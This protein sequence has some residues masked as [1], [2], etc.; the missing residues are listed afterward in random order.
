[1]QTNDNEFV[2]ETVDEQI[3]RIE[4]FGT[5]SQ[6]EK[7]SPSPGQRLIDRL[8]EMYQEDARIGERVWQQLSRHVARNNGINELLHQQSHTIRRHGRFHSMRSSSRSLT[9]IVA[10]LFVA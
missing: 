7:R 6:N 2:P 10:A 1:M 3:G 9:P 8:H 5:S 4:Q